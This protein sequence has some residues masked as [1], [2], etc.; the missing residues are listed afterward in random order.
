MQISFG[1]AIKIES[2]T[3]RCDKKAKSFDIDHATANVLHTV[4][5]RQYTTCNKETAE[6]IREFLKA[7]IGDYNRK[8]GLFAK[9][10][11]GDIYIF[12]GK[13]AKKAK[14]LNKQAR[15]EIEAMEQ[16]FNDNRLS[17]DMPERKRRA[18]QHRKEEYRENILAERDRQMLEMA[19]DGRQGKPDTKI[20][21]NMHE[22][23]PVLKS[24]SY[25]SVY[26]KNGETVREFNSLSL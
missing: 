23:S 26:D 6:K 21:F 17:K 15:L 5:G 18:I 8:T 1:R 24:I 7:Q 20:I 19:E 9:R 25:M 12:T 4:D 13:E 11:N 22:C 14:E 10:L 2:D 16:G 3:N